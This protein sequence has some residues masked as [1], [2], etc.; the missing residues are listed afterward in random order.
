MPEVRPA[1]DNGQPVFPLG[2]HTG[3]PI[4]VIFTELGAVIVIGLVA[5]KELS[6]GIEVGTK[7]EAQNTIAA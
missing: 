4:P 1:T 2:G 7:M 6:P 3:P 5:A